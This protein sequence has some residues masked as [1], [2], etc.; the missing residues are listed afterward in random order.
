VVAAG[1]AWAV[2]QKGTNGPDTLWGTNRGDTQ[3][4]KG[5]NDK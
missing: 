2:V 1:V 3:Y 5:G 4:G